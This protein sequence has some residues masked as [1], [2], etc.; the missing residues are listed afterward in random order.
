VRHVGGFEALTAKVNAYTISTYGEGL[1]ELFEDE[2]VLLCREMFRQLRALDEIKVRVPFADR[3]EWLDTSNRR[4]PS[5]FMDILIGITALHCFQREMDDEGYYLAN[6]EDFE[7]ARALFTDDVDVQELINRLTTKE[8]QFAELLVAHPEGLTRQE[9]SERLKVSPARVSQVARGQ[10]GDGGLMQKLPGFDIVPVTRRL[11]DFES[12]SYQ[13]YQLNSYDRLAGF[14]AVV[15]LKPNCKDGVSSEANSK[16]DSKGVT[17]YSSKYSKYIVRKD[18]TEPLTGGVSF[19][20]SH[21]PKKAYSAYSDSSRG[22]TGGLPVK[23]QANNLTLDPAEVVYLALQDIPPFTD[24]HGTKSWTLKKND[25]ISGLP[26][27]QAK[28]LVDRGVIREVGA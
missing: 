13:V 6:E 1:P 8:R 22:L 3:I 17:T 2:T 4:N 11:S 16:T 28:I 24:L 20:L 9:L 27:L 23:K 19:S 26:D 15:R 5:I 10:K 25:L 21:S 18:L 14:D 7:C 12:R